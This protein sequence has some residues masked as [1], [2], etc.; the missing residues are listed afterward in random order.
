MRVADA[1]SGRPV[2]L[3]HGFPELWFSWRHQLPALAAAGYHA[4]APDQRGY[5]GTSAPAD[6]GAYDVLTLAADVLA[7]LDRL[8]H[9]R[10]VVVGHDW[11]AEVAWRL[12]LVHPERVDAVVGMSVPFAPR[13]PVAP[14]GVLRQRFGDSFYIVWFQRPGEADAALA[15]DVRR[16]LTA[17]EQWTDEWARRDEPPRR[18]RWLTEEELDYYAGEFE[19]TGFSGGLNW[20]R[21]ID[22]NWELMAPYAERRIERP[23][24]FVTG[25]RDPVALF[26]P[27]DAMDGWIPSLRKVTVEGAGHWVQQERPEEVTEALLRFLAEVAPAQV[28]RP[29]ADP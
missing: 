28:S 14:L 3:L 21:N 6:V 20:Y 2:V 5:G 24:L 23:A 4:I 1:G 19:R 15:R 7:L 11:G 29:P 13:P 10:A 27:G 25:S 16:T 12:A 9:E 17:N 22:R 26:M 18:P 8:G